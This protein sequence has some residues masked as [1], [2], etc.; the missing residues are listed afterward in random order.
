M[1][2]S[3]AAMRHWMPMRAQTQS[4]HLLTQRHVPGNPKFLLN[5]YLSTSIGTILMTETKS[6]ANSTRDP[7][8]K[9]GKDSRERQTNETLK[10]TSFSR[11]CDA[12]QRQRNR[13]CELTE[14]NGEN[15]RRER[16]RKGSAKWTF[17]RRRWRWREQALQKRRL[18]KL[19]TGKHLLSLLLGEDH[20]QRR[21]E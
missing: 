3:S 9:C 17:K 20:L 5:I 1:Y 4:L 21:S 7:M 6:I 18:R 14:F 11:R 12:D 10:T 13:S 19:K 2:P 8:S 15:R 16:D